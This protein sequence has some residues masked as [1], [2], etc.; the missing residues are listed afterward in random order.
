MTL[1]KL[2]VLVFLTFFF[3]HVNSSAMRSMYVD[4]FATILGDVAAEN[5]LLSYSQSNGIEILLLYD[6]HIVNANYPLANFATNTILADFIFKAKTNYGIAQMGAVGENGDFFTNVIQAYNDTRSD[7]EEQFD[8]YNLEFEFWNPSSTDPGGY[9]CDTYLI[10]NGLPCTNDGAFQFFLT[11]IQTMNTLADLSIHPITTEAYVGWP[12]LSQTTAFSFL[13]RLLVHAY[14]SNANNA[15]NYASDR[16]EDIAS[17]NNGLDVSIIFSTEP[18]FMQNWL[19]NNSMTSA[20]TIFY[21]DW[22]DAS[23]SWANNINLVG[24]TYF[25]YGFNSTITL[26]TDELPLNE[27]IAVYPNPIRTELTINYS[28]NIEQIEI[29]NNLGQLILET[30]ETTIDLNELSNGIYTLR[31]LTDEGLVIEKIVKE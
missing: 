20:E 17:T 3:V 19:E 21:N 15:Y 8:I 28:G 31:M 4:N 18:G 6:L 12:T 9:Y 5:A 26:S 27:Q 23:I 29:Y 24:F 14:V 2:P 25:T 13:D 1:K 7:H 11:Q 10:P 16:L 30:N 22:Q